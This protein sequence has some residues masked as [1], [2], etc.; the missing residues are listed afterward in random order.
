MRN[1]ESS[2]ASAWSRTIGAFLS[3]S[4]EAQSLEK[5]LVIP[6][7]AYHLIQYAFVG[8]IEKRKK[9]PS[10]VS[11]PYHTLDQDIRDGNG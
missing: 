4:D 5:M 2:K 11:I 7:T 6:S 3:F 9:R 8:S 10:A 1:L